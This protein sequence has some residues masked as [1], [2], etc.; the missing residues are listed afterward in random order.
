MKDGAVFNLILKI[1]QDCVLHELSLKET[2]LVYWTIEEPLVAKIP[3]KVHGVV[4][5]EEVFAEVPS[6]VGQL[7]AE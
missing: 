7:V 6:E 1:H 4:L 3:E 5:D 2:L